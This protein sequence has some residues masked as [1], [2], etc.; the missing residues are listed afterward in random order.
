VTEDVRLA[1]ARML[2][3]V[4]RWPDAGRVLA[5]VLAEH[6]ESTAAWCLLALCHAGSRLLYDALNAAQHAVACDPTDEWALRVLA[7]RLRALD[8]TDE[9]IEA[10]RRAMALAPDEWRT[11][12]A[13]AEMLADRP[14]PA[15]QVSARAAIDRASELA[16]NQVTVHLVDGNIASGSGDYARSQ[17]AWRRAL[18]I[19]PTNDAALHNVALDDLDRGR[20]VAA[21]RGFGSAAALAP[22]DDDHPEHVGLAADAVLWRLARRCALIAVAFGVAMAPD[23]AAYIWRGPIATIT[24]LAMAVVGFRTVRRLPAGARRVLVGRRDREDTKTALG[25]IAIQPAF[26]AVIGYAPW[27]LDTATTTSAQLL[28]LVAFLLVAVS[29]FAA[30]ASIL[31]ERRRPGVVRLRRLLRHRRGRQ[32]HDGE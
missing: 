11:H 3:A 23:T 29:W 27:L 24:L 17:R 12:T 21:M 18:E 7:Y 2:L 31:S 28:V 1:Q 32:V 4:K 6:P 16:P 13:Y 5:D 20:H 14:T 19:D 10:A 8:R 26:V 25:V 15:N 30:A 9:A 22:D